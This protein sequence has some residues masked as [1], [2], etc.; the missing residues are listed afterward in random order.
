MQPKNQ[1]AFQKNF[2][3]PLKQRLYFLRMLPMALLTGTRLRVLNFE[4][5][6]A[7]VP[8]FWWN[9]NPFGSIYFAVMSMAAELSTAAPAMLAIKGCEGKIALIIVDM[10]AVFVKKAKTKITFTCTDYLAIFEELQGLK[11]TGDMVSFTTKTEGTNAQNE[12][13]AAFEFTWMFKRQSA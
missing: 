12:V 5:A 3:H 11:N 10:K 6:Q 4:K 13:V 9:K 8:F 7:T 1:E 2:L